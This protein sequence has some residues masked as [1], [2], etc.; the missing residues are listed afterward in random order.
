MKQSKLF[1]AI[2]LGLSLTLAACDP[3]KKPDAGNG[4]GGNGGGNVTT[5][6]KP[7][8]KFVVTP[9]TAKVGEEVTVDASTSTDSDGTVTKHYIKFGDG[10]AEV[11]SSKATHKYTKA[12][13]YTISVYVKDDKDAKSAVATKTITIT[14]ATPTPPTPPTNAKPVAKFKVSATEV[15]VGTEVT[16]DA[17]ESKDG[18]GDVKKYHFDFGDGTKK[19]F[20]EDKAKHTYT[21]AGIYTVTLK[22]EDDK[23]LASDAVTKT[24]VVKAK[25]TPVVRPGPEPLPGAPIVEVDN[26]PTS[27]SRKYKEMPVVTWKDIYMYSDDVQGYGLGPVIFNPQTEGY[28]IEG[29]PEGV[30]VHKD[31]AHNRVLFV[32][33]DVKPGKYDLKLYVYKGGTVNGELKYAKYTFKST[34]NVLENKPVTDIEV[35]IKPNV[36]SYAI[37]L[38][39]A[40]TEAIDWALKN[41][42][43][44]KG[45]ILSQGFAIDKP[46]DEYLNLTLDV[47]KYL[48]QLDVKKDLPY[49]RYNVTST[50]QIK[51][52]PKQTLTEEQKK[53]LRDNGYDVPESGEV[54]L[55]HQFKIIVNVVP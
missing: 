5:N 33:K 27:P 48:V 15:A 2:F 51:V 46:Y 35:T 4:N 38:P 50:A 24:V 43:G 8:A 26:P 25:P 55:K 52:K 31:K 32:A 39:Q 47:K 49:G 41:Y 53:W 23:G 14:A 40:A 22:V 12:G 16:F 7:V 29:L 11:K 45:E 34:L 36:D 10:S 18:D 20:T 30:T 37:P 54:T 9:A 44:D 28:K 13:T 19:S 21:K 42:V 6:A 17:D 1:G 3:P